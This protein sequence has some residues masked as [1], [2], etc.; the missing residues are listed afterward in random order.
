MSAAAVQINMRSMQWLALF[1]VILACIVL[2]LEVLAA[3][4]GILRYRTVTEV[5]QMLAYG[6]IGYFCLGLLVTSPLALFWPAARVFRKLDSR[7]IGIALG[8]WLAMIWLSYTLIEAGLA[9]A[10]A[11]GLTELSLR[12]RMKFATLAVLAVAATPILWWPTATAYWQRRLSFLLPL[13][14]IVGGISVL[15]AS[16]ALLTQHGPST[17]A[18]LPLQP[19]ASGRPHVILLSIDTLAAKH[20]SVYGYARQ[21]TPHLDALAKQAHVF[22][23]FYAN[24]NFTTPSVNSLINGVRPWTHRVVHVGGNSSLDQQLA[25]SGLAGELKKGGYQTYA[26]AT[27]MWAAPNQNGSAAWFDKVLYGKANIARVRLSGWLGH[28]PLVA[29]L[30]GRAT[31]NTATGVVNQTMRTLGIWTHNNHY[32]PDLAFAAAREM[33]SDAPS[34]APIF[35]WVHLLPPHDPYAAPRPF[36][37]T[38][39]PRPVSATRHNS[40][41][42]YAFLAGSDPRFPHDYVPRYDESILYV[43]HHVGEFFKWLRAK[44]W[45]DPSL[46]LVTSDHGESFSHGYGG[47]TGVALFEDL[48]HIP[49]LVKLPGQAIGSR[50]AT[51]AEQVDVVP[52]ILD[53][54]GLPASSSLEGRSLM[55]PMRGVQAPA[56]AVFSMNFERASRFGKL[57]VGTVA[58]IDGPWKYVRYIGYRPSDL[59]GLTDALYDVVKDPAE[60]IDQSAA[61]PLVSARLRQAIDAQMAARGKRID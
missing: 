16:F 40:S 12:P 6:W 25:A 2:P 38:F 46:I 28:L 7:R 13:G 43:D 15:T 42:P 26:V 39:D 34:Q 24:S 56:P 37:G 14:L 22:D 49:L 55:P 5:L 36:L 59:H 53:A 23:R 50:V 60:T 58:I 18:T 27:N 17:A 4:D 41:P 61:F 45:F 33:L 19:Q 44:G 57:S 52:T 29:P 1:P 21:T 9:W 51:T 54:V 20:M 35:L 48:I 11:V 3:L 8:I 31:V 47:H 10:R 30:L 32:D